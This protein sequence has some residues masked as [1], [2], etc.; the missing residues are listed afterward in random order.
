MTKKVA[1]HNLNIS[2]VDNGSAS[3]CLHTRFVCLPQVSSMSAGY[4]LTW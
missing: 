1:S 4:H 3:C 2:S